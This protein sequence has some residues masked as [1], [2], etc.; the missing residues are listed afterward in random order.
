MQM[1]TYDPTVFEQQDV[2]AA[3]RIIV[4]PS[5]EQSSEE[6]W[7]RETPY[8]GAL[9]VKALQLGPGHLV[10][11]YGCGIGRVAKELIARSG[12]SVLGVDLSVQM[13]AHA[14]TYVGGSAFSAVSRRV[15]NDLVQRGL[16]VD[17]AISVWVLQHA[18]SPAEDIDLIARSLKPGGSAGIVNNLY[19]AVPT[20]EVGWMNDGVDIRALLAE[21][22]KPEVVGALDPA[23]VSPAVSEITFWGLYRA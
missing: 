13:R 1:R 17:A 21:R 18:H 22:L 23:V 2:E 15:F 14:P 19:R 11:D 5:P 12:C 7:E 8:L 9:F 3:R 16:R 6:R 4:T 20:K 10:V